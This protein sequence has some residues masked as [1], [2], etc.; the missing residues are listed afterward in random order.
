[1]TRRS[2]FLADGTS[3]LPLARHLEGICTDL[4]ADITV[5]PVDPTLLSGA[6]RTVAGRLDFLRRQGIG[7]DVVFV[8]RD[9]EGQDPEL[10]R[11]E[12]AAGAA[13][14]GI[15]CP[16]VPVVP[17]RMTEAWLLLDE[18]AIRRVA[19]KPLGRVALDL[20]T[21]RE[22]ERR[23]HPKELLADVLLR[24]SETAGRRRQQFARDFDRHRA[25]L[26]ERLDSTRPG[27]SRR[28]R[29]GDDSVM[30]RLRPSQHWRTTCE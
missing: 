18:S 20:P 27:R 2:V 10:R 11:S 25:L 14:V 9:A 15:R 5:A 12:I 24:A 8:H 13:T 19:G 7:Y 22:V 1:M 3:D 4:G 16:V 17:I 6:G 23:A 29:R 26:L 21:A 28:C 30:T